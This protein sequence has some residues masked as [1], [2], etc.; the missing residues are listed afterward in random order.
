MHRDDGGQT[1][2]PWIS[3]I[4]SGLRDAMVSFLS[5]NLLFDI[6]LFIVSSLISYFISA[7][8]FPGGKT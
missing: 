3:C 2:P 4:S 5:A 6:F 1:L 7:A 8:L